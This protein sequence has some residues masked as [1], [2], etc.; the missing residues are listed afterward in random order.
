MKKIILFLSLFC[1]LCTPSQV[2]LFNYYDNTPVELQVSL[3]VNFF[4]S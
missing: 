4:V 1:I 2:M 3:T